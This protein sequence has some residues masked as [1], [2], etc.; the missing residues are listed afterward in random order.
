MICQL[1]EILEYKNQPV[2]NRF[3]KDHPEYKDQAEQIFEDLMRFFWASQKHNFERTNSSADADLDFVFIMDE[4]MRII[5]Q[6]WHVFLLY[7]KDY[8]DFSYK[9]FGE[10]IHHLPDL[11]PQMDPN[12]DK[13]ETNLRRFLNYSYDN[14][15]ESVLRRW[16]VEPI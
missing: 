13:F 15:G 5:D 4:K 2:I 10:Y 11:V 6:M 3:I 9:Y 14:L 16:F 8:M 1:N 7:T 12:P